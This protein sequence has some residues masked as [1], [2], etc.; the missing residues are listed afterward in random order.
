MFFFLILMPVIN[1][2]GSKVTE[3]DEQ[4]CSSTAIFKRQNKK[5][6]S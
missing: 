1:G 6:K 5:N 2:S 3:R 4:H